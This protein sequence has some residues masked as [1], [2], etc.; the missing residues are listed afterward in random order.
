M[1][2][3]ILGAT[4]PTGRLIVK[5]AQ[6]QGHH[7]VALVRSRA[8]AAELTGATLV[9]GDARDEAALVRAMVGCDAVISSLGTPMSPFREVTLLSAA[10]KVLIGVM[11]RQGVSRLVCITG[12]GAGDS[13]GHGGF[14]FDHIFQPLML[15]RV[16]EDK[17]R[18]EVLVRGS[19]LD[20]VIVRPSVLTDK[21]ES[22]NVRALTNLSD[23]HGGTISRIDVATF[24]VQQLGATT[25]LHQSPLITW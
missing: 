19:D 17:D 15:G 12:M 2:I 14:F 10:T 3:L 23:M 11:K 21:R 6:T 4:G 13:H 16:Y 22:R 18:Q 24:V 5:Q 9:E 8:K 1:K 25:W 20:W 7:V